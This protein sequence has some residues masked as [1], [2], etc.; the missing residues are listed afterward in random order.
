MVTIVGKSQEHIKECTC[1]NC[2]TRLQYTL[3]EVQSHYYRDYD[4]SGDT[5]YFIICPSC[6]KK[7]MVENY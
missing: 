7:V 6:A 1:R 5:D 2:S 3:S 4:G